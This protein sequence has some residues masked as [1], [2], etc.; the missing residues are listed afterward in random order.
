M[1]GDEEQDAVVVTPPETYMTREQT[2]NHFSR[3][4]VAARKELQDDNMIPEGMGQT[5]FVVA[6]LVGDAI[7]RSRLSDVPWDIVLHYTA[8]LAYKRGKLIATAAGAVPET[9]EEE[10]ESG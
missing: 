5:D 8:N 10:E 6:V 4:Y 7:R 3:N 9:E 1:L 2:G